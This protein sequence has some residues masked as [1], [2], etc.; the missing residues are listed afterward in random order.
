MSTA[1]RRGPPT[2]VTGDRFWFN[3]L[4]P[5]PGMHCG[6]PGRVVGFRGGKDGALWLLSS[7]PDLGGVAGRE[8]SAG[9]RQP[10]QLAP[11]T[12]ECSGFPRRGLPVVSQ[13]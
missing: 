6:G 11:G 1:S 4:I 3:R 9:R 7:E 13:R 2:V 5:R 8:P 10:S 12:R